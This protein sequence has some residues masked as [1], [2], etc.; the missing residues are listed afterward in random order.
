MIPFLENYQTHL[1]KKV[2][3][4]WN[5]T[6][7]CWSVRHK[8]KVLFH[9]SYLELDDCA[10]KVSEAAKPKY[11]QWRTLMFYAGLVI[12]GLALSALITILNGDK[13]D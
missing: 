4:Y 11:N 9:T 10:L 8:G 5:L 3:V 1:G 12:I 13:H 6:K 2:Y 7:K